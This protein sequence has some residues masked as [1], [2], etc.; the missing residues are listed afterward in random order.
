[1]QA[2]SSPRCST[3]ENGPVLG[4]TDPGY[5]LHPSDNPLATIQ[6]QI[7]EM[8]R[9][10]E[11]LAQVREKLFVER[12]RLRSTGAAV[13]MQR[14][15]MGN[16]EG[17][18][19][20][21]LRIFLHES[22]I[23]LPSSIMDAYEEIE[24]ARDEMGS[25][26]DDFL[27]DERAL[28]AAEQSFTQ[29]ESMF[30]QHQ[31]PDVF[32]KLTLDSCQHYI[33]S[34]APHPPP[35]PDPVNL[36]GDVVLVH[37]AP[38][39]PPPTPPFSPLNVSEPPKESQNL[40]IQPRKIVTT[41]GDVELQYN[42]AMKELESLRKEFD[43]FRPHQS[44]ILERNHPKPQR[45]FKL[46]ILHTSHSDFEE[47]Y[48]NVLSRLSDCEVKVQRLRVRTAKFRGMPQGPKRRKSDPVCSGGQTALP[49]LLMT[50]AQTVVSPGEY[51]S[52]EMK[53][54]VREW[55][56]EYSR[57]NP[58]E[59]RIYTNILEKRG[60]VV[61]GD[62]S[63]KERTEEYWSFGTAD[64]SS[65]STSDGSIHTFGNSID[66]PRASK[67]QMGDASQKTEMDKTRAHAIPEYQYSELGTDSAQNQGCEICSNSIAEGMFA[68][69]QDTS[70]ATP[71]SFVEADLRNTS[72]R[73]CM[74][75]GPKFPWT[76]NH[77]RCK[78]ASSAIGQPKAVSRSADLMLFS[79][80][81]IEAIPS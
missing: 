13:R 29:R 81:V 38:P 39:P 79:Q 58:I 47:K 62:D 45:N 10:Q 52:T 21:F 75:T 56:L 33:M 14:I 9:L 16:M 69:N 71:Y 77:G 2:Y 23:A 11:D 68:V 4:H 5:F 8:S 15:K 67:L 70:N 59:R 66:Q 32:N 37:D 24:K 1:M 55:M 72:T 19:M 25:S 36:A 41:A 28:G 3:N 22:R 54:R 48:S 80:H 31:C 46:P 20:N 30:Y 26:E 74:D 51:D 73:A 34:D 53:L 57:N 63:L 27:E 6:S 18:F 43:S 78:S 12:T 35:P 61:F 44:E 49:N 64:G 42:V 76:S 60:V 7:R 40:P 50:R 65:F 17:Q